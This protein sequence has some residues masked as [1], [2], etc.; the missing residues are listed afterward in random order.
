[1]AGQSQTLKPAN[2][3]ALDRYEDI[4]RRLAA[5]VDPV[6]FSELCVLL[7]AVGRTSQQLAHDV[8]AEK[9]RTEGN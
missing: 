6:E 3:A 7:C 8:A 4:V 1:M 9:K 5:D 2:C